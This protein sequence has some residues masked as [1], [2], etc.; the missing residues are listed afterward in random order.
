MKRLG[1]KK[2]FTLVECLVAMAVLAVLTLALM[3][4]LSVTIK[5][6]NSNMALEREIDRQVQD[7]VQ[8]G[9][10]VTT[11]PFNDDIEFKDNSGDTVGSIPGNGNGVTANKEFQDNELAD[12]EVGRLD[13]DFEDYEFEDVEGGDGGSGSTYG[14]LYKIYGA[15]NVGNISITEIKGSDSGDFCK[16]TW[17]VNFSA[18]DVA[19]ERAVKITFPKTAKNI[20]C[21]GIS[22][23]NSLSISK[24]V[25]RIQPAEGGTTAMYTF[26][27]STAGDPDSGTKS[28]LE[29]Y[30]CVENYIKGSGSG[31]SVNIP[32]NTY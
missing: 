4:T 15:A 16:I 28:D 12:V 20:T 25:M 8:D 30:G 10:E 18:S 3:M 9:A 13:Y 1:N 7:I 5:A 32:I 27:L 2:G 24:N 21:T 23:G 14:D 31:N 6:R 11:A 17:T 19:D 26:E 29:N 22:G